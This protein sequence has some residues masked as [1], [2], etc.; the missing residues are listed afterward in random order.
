MQQPGLDPR[1]FGETEVKVQP[2]MT[3]KRSYKNQSPKVGASEMDWRGYEN[4][5]LT[6]WVIKI[7]SI[8]LDPFIR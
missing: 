5:G 1:K 4:T 6:N 2:G 3:G 8:Y 7:K